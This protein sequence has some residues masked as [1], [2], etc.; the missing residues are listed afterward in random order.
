MPAEK[1]LSP[2]DQH[3]GQLHQS[4]ALRAVLLHLTALLQDL[5]VRPPE[6]MQEG[7]SVCARILSVHECVYVRGMC[8]SICALHLPSEEA[9]G[10]KPW[11]AEAEDRAGV[12]RGSGFLQPLQSAT[13][14]CIRARGHLLVLWG[15]ELQEAVWSVPLEAL[16][17]GLST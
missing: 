11:R 1:T 12:K 5:R 8:E 17:P 6:C 14:W 3:E 9:L 10:Q 15:R 4:R 13:G 7:L 2:G 16:F